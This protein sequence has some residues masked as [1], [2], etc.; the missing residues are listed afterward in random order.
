MES[1]PSAWSGNAAKPPDLRRPGLRDN[2]PTHCLSGQD[3]A[4]IAGLGWGAAIFAGRAAIFAG[5]GWQ[6]EGMLTVTAGRDVKNQ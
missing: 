6:W 2:I 5:L 4:K 1:G 3:Q